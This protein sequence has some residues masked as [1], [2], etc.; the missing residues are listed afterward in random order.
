MG[1]HPI[2]ESDFDCLI[3]CC[4]ESLHVLPIIQSTTIFR[5]LFHLLLVLCFTCRCTLD[6]HSSGNTSQRSLKLLPQKV[7]TKKK[8]KMMNKYLI[9]KELTPYR[10]R[11]SPVRQINYLLELYR[12]SLNKILL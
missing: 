6:Q 4:L 5:G 3:E 11:R 1:T 2:F 12:I 8:R 10:L 7:T 9:I